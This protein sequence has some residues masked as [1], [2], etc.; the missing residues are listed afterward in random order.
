MPDAW[1]I[2]PHPPA[3]T[4]AY[5]RVWPAGGVIVTTAEVGLG[6]LARLDADPRFAVETRAADPEPS[7]TLPLTLVK[8][9]G[10][11]TAA[12]LTAAGID[13]LDVL[14]GLTDEAVEHVAGGL[15]VVGDAVSELSAWRDAARRLTEP[16]RADS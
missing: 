1:R 11:K 3:D 14:A 4:A 8:G 9:I 15:E 10:P 5:G 6:T 16:A 13:T 2:T 7:L 12:A